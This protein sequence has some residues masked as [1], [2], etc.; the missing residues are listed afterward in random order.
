[1]KRELHEFAK[2]AMAL[3]GAAGVAVLFPILIVG[4]PVALAVRLVLAS[5]GWRRNHSAISEE[6]V[7]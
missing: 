3:L 4:L 7:H 1:M 6:T 5:T 2:G